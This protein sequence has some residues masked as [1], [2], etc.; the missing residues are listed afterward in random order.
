MSNV[1]PIRALHVLRHRP[2]QALRDNEGYY[3]K[4]VPES[5]FLDFAW[6]ETLYTK[7]TALLWFSVLG[8]VV[9]LISLALQELA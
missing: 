8:L 6:L 5:D 1:S 3:E 9:C 2:D 7:V 4:D